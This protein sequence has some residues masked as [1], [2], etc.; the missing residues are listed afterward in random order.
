MEKEVAETFEAAKK[1]ADATAAAAEG[2]GSP[3][4]DRCVGALRRLRKMT[5]TTDIL[6]TTQVGKRLR[7]LT[8]HSHPK[9]KAAASDLLGFWKNIV[10]KESSSG[11][12]SVTSEN[13]KCAKLETKSAAPHT[14]KDK[15]TPEASSLKINKSAA[16][17][18]IKDKKTPEASSVKINKSAAPHTIKD[19]KTP[20]AS[21]VKINK[22]AAPHTIKDKKTPVASSV[23]INKVRKSAS[24]NAPKEESKLSSIPKSSSAP[25]APP[26]F[27]SLVK[28]DDPVR[29][30][31]RELLAETFSKVSEETGKDARDEVRNI[32]DEV[33]SCDPI[34][35]AATVESA[36]FEKL[37]SSAGGR[38]QKYRSIMF[39]L[40]AD[41]NTDLRRRVLIG[42]VRPES[43]AD[44]SPEDMA[45]DARK[46]ANNKIKEKALFDCERGGPPKATT[47][48]FKCG[49][50]GQR[51]ATYYQMQTRS[52]DEPMTTF[53]TCVNCNNHWKFC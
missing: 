17:H 45:S 11:K 35:A 49:R 3:E 44:M 7:A 21:S 24:L 23:K 1:A 14:I 47:D 22:S 6:V 50:C 32:L 40:R 38:K 34:R 28:C 31:I 5:V 42:Q 51:K 15:K 20:E 25:L 27:A 29:D 26:K 37:G 43:L 4:A 36:L 16:P 52:A 12:K 48:Q 46:L 19:K 41:N 39:N 30:K 9:I 33:K 53:V 18:T 13:K 8:K 10:I 2:G